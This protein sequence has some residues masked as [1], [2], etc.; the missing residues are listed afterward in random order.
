MADTA[1][2]EIRNLA[3]IA[4]VDHGKTTLVDAMLWQSE[5][6]R[7]VGEDSRLVLDA[8]DPEREKSIN[9]ML[10]TTSMLFRETRINIVDT[11]SRA[12]FGRDV[13]RALRIVD[14]VLLVVDGC[15]GPLPQ[16]RFALRK[17]LEAG[18]APIVVVTKIDRPYARPAE[19][20]DEVRALFVDLEASE[21]QLG[22]PVL[23]CNALSGRCRREPSADD[24]S[25][26]PLFELILDSVPPPVFSP[27]GGLQ[28]L[29][30]LL[31]Y[32]D[33][34]GRHGSRARGQRWSLE[35]RRRDRG[36]V[37]RSTV[38]GRNR[39]TVTGLIRATMGCAG[40]SRSIEAGPGDIVAV[41]G[42]ATVGIGETLS[43]P[44]ATR[45]R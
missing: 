11:P 29:V 8:I 32:D 45:R 13:E 9:V 30:T 7:E 12:D 4:H 16:T 28:F 25:L 35:A 40:E 20:L 44:G 15:E 31:D 6:V 14:G 34:L 17:A 43:D 5:R 27:G 41:G 33:F 19:V 36:P 22:F 24:E 39:C 23:Y 3:I 18:L 1:H 38:P 42:L 21:E 26:L 37:P 2:S 10:K